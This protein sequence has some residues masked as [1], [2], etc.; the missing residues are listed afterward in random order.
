M[1]GFGAPDRGGSRESKNSSLR[2]NKKNAAKALKDGEKPKT[3]RPT[4]SER[5]PAALPPEPDAKTASIVDAGAQLASRQFD[6]DQQKARTPVADSRHLP[7]PVS[8]RL[9]HG[10]LHNV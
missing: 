2:A 9:T 6:R 10:P 1:G 5:P 3:Q 7:L 4:V 8:R